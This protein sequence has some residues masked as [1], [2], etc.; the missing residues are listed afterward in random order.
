MD[1][2]RVSDAQ[3]FLPGDAEEGGVT[4]ALAQ[5]RAN[6]EKMIVAGVMFLYQ[7]FESRILVPRVYGR[8]LRL[9]AATVISAP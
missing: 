1:T 6:L 8:V 2:Q 7:E 3:G 5:T 4:L 9:S